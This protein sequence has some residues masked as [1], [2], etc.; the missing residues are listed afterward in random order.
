MKSKYFISKHVGCLL[1]K[2]RMHSKLSVSDI[3]RAI[4]INEETIHN[5]EKGIQSISVCIL[6]NYLIFINA[7]IL[8]FFTEVGDGF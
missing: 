5:Y 6:L 8:D 3:S 4:N 7:N 1:E 2:Y